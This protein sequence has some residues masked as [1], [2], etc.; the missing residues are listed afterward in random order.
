M[1]NFNEF[2]QSGTAPQRN[3]SDIFSH[4]FQVYG[5]GIGWALLLFLLFVIA[6]MVLSMVAGPLVGYNP[7]AANEAMRDAG[8]PESFKDVM[9][10]MMAIPGIQAYYAVSYILGLLL[11]PFYAGFQLIFHKA[12]VG[13]PVMFSD[14]FV[15]FRKNALQYIIFGLISGIVMGIAIMLCFVPVFFVIPFFFLGMPILLFE[16]VSAMDALK[17]SFTIG[18]ENYGTLLGVGVVSLLIA[19]A[20]VVLCGIGVILSFPFYF[21]AMYSAYCAFVG[22]PKQVTA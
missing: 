14:L 4:A 12:N 7:M 9:T 8:N 13:Q 19:I 3:F 15:G 10:Q 18:K 22:V 17:K 20:G 2:D 1:E 6:S 21:A 5:K 11:Y 16:N